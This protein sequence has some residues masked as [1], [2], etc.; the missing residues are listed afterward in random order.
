VAGQPNRRKKPD[1]KQGRGSTLFGF[2]LK[3][4]FMTHKSTT[5]SEKIME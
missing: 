1:F 4:D 2:F 5:Q 3:F